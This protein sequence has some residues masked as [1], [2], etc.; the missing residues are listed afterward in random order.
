MVTAG[1]FASPLHVLER[2]LMAAELLRQR[3]ADRR[4]PGVTPRG[5]RLGG[6]TLVAAAGMTMDGEGKEAEKPDKPGG[7]SSASPTSSPA[8]SWPSGP[9]GR[10]AC[11]RCGVFSD[12]H[13]YVRVETVSEDGP[14]SHLTCKRCGGAF[15]P[16]DV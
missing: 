5:D 2:L 14:Q 8:R 10:G 16:S 3:A 6:E 13:D 12:D 11:P 4:V 1:A 9:T 7:W 15:G